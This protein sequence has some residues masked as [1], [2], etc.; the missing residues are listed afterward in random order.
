MKTIAI[1]LLL[2]TLAIA[3]ALWADTLATTMTVKTTQLKT[4]LTIVSTSCNNPWT[5]TVTT[6]YTYTTWSNITTLTIK[7]SK[8]G[9]GGPAKGTCTLL[10]RFTNYG[11]PVKLYTFY[12]IQS[13]SCQISYQSLS[14]GTQ[15]EGGES[16][17]FSLN[18]QNCNP[19]TVQVTI[20]ARAWNQ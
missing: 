9:Q 19:T 15:I 11:M 1:A 4:S 16:R 7:V 5:A 12:S 14:N 18:L 20:T 8:P 2:T 10:L 17:N 3:T 13:G 6:S